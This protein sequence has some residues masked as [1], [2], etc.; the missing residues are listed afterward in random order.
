[1]LLTIFLNDSVGHFDG[2]HV[3]HVLRPVFAT[4]TDHTNDRDALNYA[5]EQFNVGETDDAVQYRKKGLRSL[6]VGDVVMVDHRPYSCDSC[7]WTRILR[8]TMR[9]AING[10]STKIV[11]DTGETERTAKQ[12][13]QENRGNFRHAIRDAEETLER[14]ADDSSYEDLADL[15]TKVVEMLKAWHAENVRY[16]DARR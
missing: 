12:C 7:G 11:R 4:T 10:E 8:T 9:F 14:V 15:W 16:Y 5:F 2:Y 1:M 6:S 13:L 3:S